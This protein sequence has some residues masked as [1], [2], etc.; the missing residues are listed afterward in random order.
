MF[1]NQT[2]LPLLSAMGA[3]LVVDIIPR[4][5]IVRTSCPWPSNSE[6]KA[7][8]KCFFQ[9]F[10]YFSSFVIV[11]QIRCS[12]GTPVLLSWVRV[13]LLHNKRVDLPACTFYHQRQVHVY[14]L[15]ALYM[16][17]H[18]T[19]RFLYDRYK[20]ICIQVYIHHCMFQNLSKHSFYPKFGDLNIY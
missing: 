9:K 17:I 15:S 20:T 7:P 8:F 4:D 2:S 10:E 19:V 16:T 3:C 5:L 13:F 6:N 18:T 14:I 11:R 12:G 1:S